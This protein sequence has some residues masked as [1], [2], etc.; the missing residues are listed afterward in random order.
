MNFFH[1]VMSD[2]ISF[3]LNND[4]PREARALNILK[5]WK[6][7]GHNTRYIV[8]EALLLMDDSD[9]N[10][11]KGVMLAELNEKSSHV[12][13]IFSQFGHDKSTEL[14]EI[15]S[16]LTDVNL[17]NGF[18]KAVREAARPGINLD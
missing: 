6:F 18:I 4:N 7:E 12:N 14:L 16:P 9:K 15:Y 13:Q 2:V 8:T 10:E 11:L 1:F 5:R 3:R 17:S